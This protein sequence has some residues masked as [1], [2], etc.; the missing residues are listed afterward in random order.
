MP[1]PKGSSKKKSVQEEPSNKSQK[2]KLTKDLCK[3]CDCPFQ[4][5]TSIRIG[6]IGPMCKGCYSLLAIHF[7]GLE[8]IEEDNFSV[9]HGESSDDNN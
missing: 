5:D 6:E 8:F 9:S 1:R 4:D 3:I 7:N 2:K